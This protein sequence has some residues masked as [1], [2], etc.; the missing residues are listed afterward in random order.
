MLE[1]ASLDIFSHNQAAWDRQAEQAGPWSQPVDA[2]AI[3][4]ARAGDHQA[5]LTP[6][7]LPAGWLDQVTGWRILCLASGGGQQGPLLAAA[8]AVVTVFDASEQQLERDR[9]VA[10]REGLTLTTEQGDMRDLSRFADAGFDCVFHP[11]S[12]LY[13]PDVRPVWRECFRVLCPGGRLLSSFFNPAAFI[14]DRDPAYARQGLIRPRY[15]APYSD[16]RDLEPAALAAKRAGGEALVFGH[17]LAEQ[18]GGQLESGFLLAGFHE[19][20]QPTPRFVIDG[21]LP[22]FIATWASKPEAAGGVSS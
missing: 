3:A 14:G 13:V 9:L 12:N 2:A 4:A 22:A 15:P 8:G 21:Y 10:R 20:M 7:P 6:G 16:L 19:E 18:I 5:R 1:H 11:I 17:S